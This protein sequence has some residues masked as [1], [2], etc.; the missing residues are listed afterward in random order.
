MSDTPIAY[1]GECESVV[2]CTAEGD[3]AEDQYCDHGDEACGRTDLAVVGTCEPRPEGCDLSYT[4]VCGCDGVTYGNQCEA[5]AAGQDILHLGECE[6]VVSCTAAADCDEDEY[7]DHGDEACSTTGLP[8]V[9]TCEPRP[10]DCA[11]IFDPIC[12]C[13]GVTYGNE[14]EANAAGQDV[15]YKGECAEL[16]S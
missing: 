10:E 2:T 8:V 3:C 5:N 14:C 1:E 4:P 6:L 9:G 11:S 13:D 15:L 7:C 16:S 12:G